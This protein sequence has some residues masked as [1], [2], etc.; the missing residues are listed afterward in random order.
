MSRVLILLIF[1]SSVFFLSFLP[2]KDT[3]F[4]WHYKCGE[5]LLKHGELCLKND[6]SYFLPDYKSF[7]PS[8]LYDT[9][10]AFVFDRFGFIGVSFLG[11]LVFSICAFILIKLLSG[12][13][14]VKMIAI[15]LIFFLSYSIFG[16]GLRSQIITYLFFVL[17]LF[18]INRF[19]NGSKKSLYFIPLILLIWVNTH[20][21]FFVG[22]ILLKASFFY[23]RDK[24]IIA[25]FVLSILI[26]LLNPFG[27]N[28]YKEIINHSS[29]S[30][31]T[32]IA[33]WTSPELWQEIIITTS[34]I[35]LL[36]VLLNKK[37]KNLYLIALTLFFSVLSLS[38]RRNEPFFY[39]VM[40]YVL[41]QENIVQSFFK[42]L[43]FS[44]FASEIIL[45][46]FISFFVITLGFLSIPRTIKFDTNWNEYCT[47]GQSI[48]PCNADNAIKK[49]SGNVYSMY[50]WGGFLIWRNPNI[51][52][53]VDGR[54]PAW[55]D[56]TEKS[57]Y[58][59]FLEIIQTKEGWNEKLAKFKTDYLLIQQG[60]FLDLL[61][62][63]EAQRYHWKEFYR[64][65]LA[66]I[67]KKI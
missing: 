63:K 58:E 12:F 50:E 65:D 64:D 62:Q 14:W 32:M 2:V 54:M 24:F 11:S 40:L 38:A 47:K 29:S 25:I 57:P 44:L 36:I 60:T 27:I 35:F 28:V 4:G 19:N 52:V 34:T 66:V 10:L 9:S 59:V 22:L 1:L 37:S 16:L 46:L 67:Y 41:L 8:F 45:P 56:E 15:Y 13:L 6:F 7:Y 21:G 55:K 31:N 33:E 3:D 17:T 39:T 49:L 23:K 20:I 48:Y 42:K 43:K 30:L 61:L 5:M 18:L 26:T 51:K 53:F